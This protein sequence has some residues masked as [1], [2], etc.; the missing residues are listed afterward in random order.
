[1]EIRKT[2]IESNLE[3]PFADGGV[4]AGFPSP[5]QDYMENGIDLNQLLIKHPSA[6]FYATV[7]G[8]SMQNAGI[9]NGDILI[10]DKSL[11]P[12]SGDIA[13]CYLNGEFTVK[14]IQFHG[15]EKEIH[16]IPANEAYEPVIVQKDEDFMIWGVV[17][18]C[19][20]RFV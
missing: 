16:L 4:K 19:I 15:K 9:E 12:A 13:V 20:K 3:L 8:D 1:M 17:T 10:I 2:I 11:N 6:T 14:Y 7:V 5:A 18:S